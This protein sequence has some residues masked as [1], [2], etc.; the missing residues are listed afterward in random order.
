MLSTKT[1]HSSCNA[2]LNCP[3]DRSLPILLGLFTRCISSG[4]HVPTNTQYQSKLLARFVSPTLAFHAEQTN[5][6]YDQASRSLRL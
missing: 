4:T 6:S 1:Y 5:Y 3:F 2:Y